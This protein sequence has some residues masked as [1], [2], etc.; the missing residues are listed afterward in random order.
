MDKQ[1]NELHELLQFLTDRR[2]K[3]EGLK[4]YGAKL[5]FDSSEEFKQWLLQITETEK[6]KPQLNAI[7]LSNGE[8]EQVL[9]IGQDT[10][11]G[12]T[13]TS[14]YSNFFT[15]IDAITMDRHSIIGK[16]K[17]LSQQIQ[18]YNNQNTMLQ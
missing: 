13:A 5:T 10:N 8:K 7:I 16:I 17:E 4:V 9:M 6:E 11:L 12:E 3:F 15:I 1:I 14:L 2:K 18:E